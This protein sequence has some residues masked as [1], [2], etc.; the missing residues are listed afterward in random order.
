MFCFDLIL[1]FIENVYIDTPFI[2]F[3]LC[4]DAKDLA[5][6]SIVSPILN[7]FNKF[8]CEFGVKR[9]Y[10]SNCFLSLCCDK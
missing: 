8:L 5:V 4:F 10:I 3:S 2:I 9:G 6:T 7:A 1:F